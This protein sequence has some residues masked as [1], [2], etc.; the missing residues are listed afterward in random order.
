M[1]HQSGK[2]L[3]ER[4]G[5]EYFR[6]LRKKVRRSSLIKSG[7][8]GG[9]KFIELYGKDKLKEAAKRGNETFK[10]RIKNEPYL[11]ESYRRDFIEKM[12]KFTKI[13]DTKSG[14]KVRS[15]L[16]QYIANYLTE[17]GIV[18][19]YENMQF[20]TKYGIYEPDFIV[21]NKIIEIFGMD[22][23]FYIAKKSKKLQAAIKANPKLHWIVLNKTKAN[24]PNC[25]VVNNVRQLLAIVRS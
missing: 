4:Y 23:S 14:V 21:G 18:F 15:K 12:K 9:L 6:D 25:T 10:M 17:N 19:E 1:T 5:K 20:P 8:R 24:I 13:Y 22:A 7:R 11:K 16:E 2:A 3:L